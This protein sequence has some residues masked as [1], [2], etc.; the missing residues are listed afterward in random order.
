ML[1]IERIDELADRVGDETIKDIITER[2][3]QQI[4]KVGTVRSDEPPATSEWRADTAEVEK[5]D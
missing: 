4:M 2:L 5:K 1:I 3:L